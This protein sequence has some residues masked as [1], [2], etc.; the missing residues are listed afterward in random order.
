M[1]HLSIP[2]PPATVLYARAVYEDYVP[3]QRYSGIPDENE[4][5]RG[6][7]DFFDLVATLGLQHF[8]AQQGKASRVNLVVGG[9]DE[10]TDLSFA[11]VSTSRRYRMNI[12]TSNHGAT[13][14]LHLIVKAEELEAR[15]NPAD[16]YLQA[17]VRVGT[18]IK[19]D[20][21]VKC[22]FER[23]GYHSDMLTAT[24]PCLIVLGWCVRNDAA[25]NKGAMCVI[26]NTPDKHQ[27]WLVHEND[28]RPMGDLLAMMA[29][30]I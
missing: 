12:K 22:L 28:L 30:R 21:G 5:K 24:K 3:T 14:N 8:F 1:P 20:P 10:G 16:I 27:G 29:P 15:R 17:L 4:E 26:E 9:G 2:V 11:H 7:G 6:Q 23:D 19:E 18:P 25:W 13:G